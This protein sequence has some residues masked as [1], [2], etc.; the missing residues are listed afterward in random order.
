MTFGNPLTGQDGVLVR[1]A[2]RSRNYVK[3]SAGWS[4]G[5]DG[6]GQVDSLQVLGTLGAGQVTA[7]SVSLAGRDLAAAL[8]DAPRGEIARAW[9]QIGV[10]SADTVGTTE[11]AVFRAQ[12]GQLY[13]GRAYKFMVSMPLWL[14]SGTPPAPVDIS[15]R[16]T[17]DGTTPDATSSRL[18][19]WRYHLAVVGLCPSPTLYTKYEPTQDVAN[20]RICLTLRSMVTGMVSRVYGS[21]PTQYVLTDEGLNPYNGQLAQISVASGLPET[22]GNVRYV[23]DF[24]AV[25]SAGYDGHGAQQ[26]GD[27]V[28]QGHSFAAGGQQTGLIGFDSAAI[29][30]ATAGAVVQA[31]EVVWKVRTATNPAGWS[32]IVGTTN[33]GAAPASWPPS[34][35]TVDRLRPGRAMAG[36][37]VTVDLGATIGA[38][39]A[40][41]ATKGLALGPAT[42]TDSTYAGALYGAS[43][44]AGAPVLRLTYD[45]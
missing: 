2:I 19:V 16:F 14:V 29:A 37:T 31:A 39:F 11:L 34:G 42:T 32:A 9:H 41:G 15:L 44:G 4:L 43:T 13:A 1:P 8:D 25:W 22:D 3:G 21:R 35:L 40:S 24:P 27:D 6:A 17:T 36:E 7:G 26:A 18:A 10:D 45:K 38:E 20:L 28:T 33:A 30:S 12:C 23:T 5:A